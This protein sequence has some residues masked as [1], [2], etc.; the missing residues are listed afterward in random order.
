MKN[1]L[2][3][4]NIY[5]QEELQQDHTFGDIVGQS[6][7][8]KD[9]LHKISQ[10]APLDTAALIMGETGTGKE[11]AARAIHEA[12]SRKDRPLIKLN[13]AALSASLIES[14]LFGHEKGS[15]TGAV[16]RKIG[17][18]ELANGGTL[19]LDEIVELP[20]DLQVKLLRVLQEGEFERVGSGK[21]IK[22]DVRVIASTNKNLKAEVEKRAFREDL[23]YRL[24]VFPITM[25][26]LR[27]RRED[28][29]ILTDHFMRA[30]SR[31]FGKEI[32]AVAPETMKSML[33]YSWPGNVR[34][35]ANVIERAFINSRGRVLQIKE[36][37][38]TR[39]AE[40]SAAT[41]KTL[42]EM[43]RD[44]IERILEDVQWR[45]DG[46]RGAALILGINPSTLRTRMSKLGVQKPVWKAVKESE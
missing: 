17:R 46:P 24:N 3:A 43:E 12:S 30:F 11:L 38:L 31:K 19:L 32:T 44:Y 22:T 41:A 39:Q 8:I 4:E 13:C 35:L 6:S 20:V 29:P 45:V 21:T 16:G 1:Q 23:W 15:F 27:D 9:V 14:E 7:E 42:E 18:F 40:I 5:L 10:V 36:D 34:E 33:N 28:I 25:P 2:E 37:F 26:P